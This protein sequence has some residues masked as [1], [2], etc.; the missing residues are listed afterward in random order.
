[1]LKKDIH[2]MR[3]GSLVVLGK[4]ETYH[5]PKHQ[6]WVC[7]CDCGNTKSIFSHSLTSGRTK[8]CGCKMYEGKKGINKTHGMSETRIYKEWCLMKRRCKPDSPDAKNYFDR[9]ITVCDDWNDNFLNFYEW[10]IRNKYTDDLTLD[11]IDNNKGY[12][13]DNCRWI[14]ISEQQSNKQT[15]IRIF[16][17]GKYHCL[18][19]LCKEIGFPYK[20]AHKRYSR[21]KSKGNQI[22]IQKLFAPIQENKI[23]VKYRHQQN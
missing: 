1:M 15:T 23:S 4:D 6:K 3:F 7:R 8:S 20:T 21:M 16:Y 13:P 10:S 2:G 22:D 14:S 18:R 19:T 12:S 5:H 11:R 17:E 9:Q